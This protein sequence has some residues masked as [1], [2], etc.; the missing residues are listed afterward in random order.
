MASEFADDRVLSDIGMLSM[1]FSFPVGIP[2]QIEIEGISFKMASTSIG[3]LADRYLVIKYPT[4]SISI[5]RMLFKGNKIGV[6]YL[7][8]G[9][10]FG[11]ESELI[12]DAQNLSALFISYPLRIVRKDL[13]RS[14]RM[15]CYLPAKVLRHNQDS[16]ENEPFGDGV[17]VDISR[18]G[19]GLTALRGSN[20]DVFV[21]VQ[22]GDT[23]ILNFQLPG[24]DDDTAINGK[25]K[26]VQ[27]DT[28][29]T[30]V[31]IAFET[32]ENLDTK[33]IEYVAALEELETGTVRIQ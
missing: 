1:P 15:G 32:E 20:S 8:R 29:K 14:R 10:V 21:G 7:D 2:L 23:V 24:T 11:F 18:T 31:G 26:S 16:G 33:V 28:E 13:R 30:K 5:S 4:T 22:V 3:Y 17:I 19:C 9:T 27:R 6:R 12:A 25:V